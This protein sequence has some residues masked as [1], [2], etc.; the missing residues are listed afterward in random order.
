MIQMVEELLH[1]LIGLGPLEPLLADDDIS[2][3]MIIGH[4]QAYVEKNGNLYLTDVKFRNEKHLR[5][6]IDRI[7]S[8]MG[9][10]VDESTPMVDARLEDGSRVNAVIPP[11]G[12]GRFNADDPAFLQEPLGARSSD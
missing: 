9:R 12:P 8:R 3:I 10:R 7:V 11:S 5:T 2:E 4:D 6:I 1:E